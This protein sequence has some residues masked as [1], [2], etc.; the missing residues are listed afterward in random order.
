M[1]YI[2]KGLLLFLGVITL[3]FSWG[4]GK[5]LV[6]YS[7]LSH[8]TDAFIIDWKPLKISDENF[9]IEAK[10]TFIL[11]EAQFFGKYTFDKQQFPNL[12]GVEST[13]KSLSSKKWKVW[14]NPSNFEQ[15]SLQKFF[16]FKDCFY[17]FILASLLIYFFFLGRYISNQSGSMN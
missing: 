8:Q 13:I 5:S 12:W 1:I 10:Y 9:T 6:E 3:W 11:A 4:T 15:T 7:R 16:P 14:Y 2:W 17:T